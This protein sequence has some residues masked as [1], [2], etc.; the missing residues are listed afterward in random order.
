M[1][2]RKKRNSLNKMSVEKLALFYDTKKKKKKPLMLKYHNT[3]RKL[4]TREEVISKNHF[5]CF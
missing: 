4:L 2:Y 5:I 1:N 3:D